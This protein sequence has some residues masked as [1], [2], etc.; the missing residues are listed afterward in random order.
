MKKNSKAIDEKV[1]PYIT[2]GLII[3][4]LVGALT[5]NIGLW[6]SLG[7]AFGAGVGYSRIEKK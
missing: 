2:A 6:I 5:D 3:G 4:I 1:V 7:I